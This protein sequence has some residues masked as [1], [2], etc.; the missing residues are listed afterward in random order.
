MQ[1]AHCRRPNSNKIKRQAR[2]PAAI[3]AVN[4]DIRRG[5]DDVRYDQGGGR[6]G[7][8]SLCS[9]NTDVNHPRD[10]KA[11]SAPGRVAPMRTPRR[12]DFETC[13][14]N[15]DIQPPVLPID[16]GDIMAPL[17]GNVP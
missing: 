14:R 17:I 11:G 12:E 16:R 9:G 7:S 2:K 4:P 1:R 8:P 6:A 10:S 3:Y 15:T 13:P 5:V